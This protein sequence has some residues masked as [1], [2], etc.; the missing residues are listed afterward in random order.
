MQNGHLLGASKGGPCHRLKTFP[1]ELD[2]TPPLKERKAQRDA[3]LPN[4]SGVS[5][6][7]GPRVIKLR[8]QGVGGWG[9]HG[10]QLQQPQLFTFPIQDCPEA[11]VDWRNLSENGLRKCHTGHAQKCLLPSVWSTSK[12]I[13]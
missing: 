10:D 3:R 1:D 6:V 2:M 5:S 4:V 13:L 12:I 8:K 7:G 11:R 9:V